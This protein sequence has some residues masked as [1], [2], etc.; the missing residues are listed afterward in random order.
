MRGGNIHIHTF[1]ETIS[2]LWERKMEISVAC[3]TVSVVVVVVSWWVWR[4]LQWVWFKPKML[5]SY[6]R[7]QGLAGTPYTP[8]VGDLK[9]N[10][11]MRAEARS[12]PINLTDDITPR[13]VPYPLQMLKTH[14]MLPGWHL[15]SSLF[16]TIL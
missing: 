1:F 15:D 12:K 6:L 9:K 3:V 11:S 2:L 16:R 7:R 13:I 8:L 10:F 4:T 5:E 14:G